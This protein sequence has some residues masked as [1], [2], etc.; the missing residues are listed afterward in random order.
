MFIKTTVKLLVYRDKPQTQTLYLIFDRVLDFNVDCILRVGLARQLETLTQ[1]TAIQFVSIFTE[2][3]HCR[4]RML[5]LID[6]CFYVPPTFCKG[7]RDTWS[8]KT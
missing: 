4:W 5:I 3:D 6:L 1:L 2:K 7:Q 8:W